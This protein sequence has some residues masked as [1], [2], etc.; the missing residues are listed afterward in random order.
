MVKQN[1]KPRKESF[2]KQEKKKAQKWFQKNKG[3]TVLGAFH[4]G[5]EFLIGSILGW[6]LAFGVLEIDSRLGQFL[7]SL[8]LGVVL[9]SAW[10]RQK[11]F[12]VMGR[13][14][15]AESLRKKLVR[16]RWAVIIGLFV[17]TFYQFYALGLFP[18]L[19][20]NP[21]RN[22][23]RIVRSFEGHYPYFEHKDLDW[24][25]MITSTREQLNQVESEREYLLTIQNFLA[26]ID[27]AH[28]GLLAPDVMQSR[29]WLGMVRNLGNKPIVMWMR[30]GA[31]IEG[32]VPGS[33]ILSRDGLTPEEFIANL[34]PHKTAGSSE[35][36]N[37]YMA[38]SSL[39]AIYNEE[40]MVL[41]YE[42]PQGEVYV[43]ELNWRDEYY[44]EDVADSLISG[45][46]LENNIG[47]I[48]IPSF[49]DGLGYDLQQEFQTALTKLAATDSLI[50]DIRNNN[51]GNNFMA[52]II[53]GY[54]FTEA[55]VY[56][57]EH[58]QRKLPFNLW[59]STQNRLLQPMEIHYNNPVVLLVDVVNMG[60]AELFAVMFKDS[61][62]GILV[63]NTT[64][65]AY[66]NPAAFY[67]NGGRVR[68]PLADFQRDSGVSI[69]GI[70]ITPHYEVLYNREDL[71]VGK[72]SQLLKAIDLLLN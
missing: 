67:I 18:P 2:S 52:E 37:D 5:F 34:A 35:H 46:I 28:I 59:R 68:M 6:V 65:G 41:E 72:D 3:R 56:G 14:R 7:G 22:F 64:A 31:E 19:T 51:G 63:G 11:L 27:D 15:Q 9:A 43:K 20:S 53:A 54:F 12:F 62:R 60:A 38:Y 8:L 4:L 61:N 32:L 70:G 16:G 1:K 21:Q 44:G 23:S 50:L 29:H 24:E 36:Q 55:F 10:A 30:E 69:E 45:E 58:Y 40:T 33:I 17:I 48:S 25:Q 71:I 47:L 39:L 49:Y 42:S 66:G 57:T 26:S 13:H